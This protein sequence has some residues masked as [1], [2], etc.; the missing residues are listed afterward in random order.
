MQGGFYGCWLLG[1]TSWQFIIPAFISMIQGLNYMMS[2]AWIYTLCTRIIVIY[3]VH[4]A[5][6]LEQL[7]IK[8]NNY[9]LNDIVR[10]VQMFKHLSQATRLLHRR[11]ELILLINC[12]F[13][14]ANMIYLMY[15]ITRYITL[16][17]LIVELGDCISLVDII[18]RLF[19]ICHSA[20][21]LRNSVS[22]YFLLNR[23][24]IS[25]KKTGTKSALP[26]DTA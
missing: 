3:Y 5:N 20:D 22:K 23:S 2:A 10:Y 8:K 4:I 13:L 12:Y 15:Y 16:Y 25:L 19:L 9:Y 14:I 21:N 1:W 11:F 18:F 17:G 26:S 24:G 6:K 7:T